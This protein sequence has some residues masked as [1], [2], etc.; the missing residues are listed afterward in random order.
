[1]HD[2]IDT[3]SEDQESESYWPDSYKKIIRTGL[4]ALFPETARNGVFSREILE[5]RFSRR[6]D[7]Y[8]DAPA[9]LARVVGIGAENGSDRVLFRMA[10][11]LRNGGALNVVLPY[12]RYL[13]PSL[14]PDEFQQ[15]IRKESV[16]VF[17]PEHILKH[18]YEDFYT[19]AYGTYD[20]FIR[21]FTDQLLLG[22]V[23]G[24][25]DMLG[26]ILTAFALELPL[27]PVRRYPRPLKHW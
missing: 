12:H 11:R 2:V 25:D 14:F 5:K 15:E 3:E 1:L 16:A 8:D 22:A 17:Y 4:S 18:V 9:Y 21:I 6:F 7:G 19:G 13:R 26:M 23:N 20:H 10:S 24:A 27:P